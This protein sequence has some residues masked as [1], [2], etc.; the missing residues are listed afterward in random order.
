MEPAPNEKRVLSFDRTR[1]MYEFFFF[2]RLLWVRAAPRHM[3][4]DK[5]LS[6]L[7]RVSIG[8][9]EKMWGTHTNIST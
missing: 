8:Y 1:G 5:K 3:R 9:I 7:G 6:E 2:V 4:N